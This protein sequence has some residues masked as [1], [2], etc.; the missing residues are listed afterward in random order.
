MF[1]DLIGHIPYREPPCRV[2]PVG[3][4]RQRLVFDAAGSLQKKGKKNKR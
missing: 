3:E 4:T 1:A 2:E